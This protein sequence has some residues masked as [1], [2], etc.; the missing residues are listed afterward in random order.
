[1]KTKR[2]VELENQV[3][4][5]A[6][7]YSAESVHGDRANLLSLGFGIGSESCLLSW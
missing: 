6:A 7:D 4:R 5:E 2:F 3:G 1:M